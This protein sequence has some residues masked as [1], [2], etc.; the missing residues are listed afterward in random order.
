MLLE[1]GIGILTCFLKTYPRSPLRAVVLTRLFSAESAALEAV[2]VSFSNAS[3]TVGLTMEL[4]GT[5]MVCF[6]LDL[7]RLKKDL[8]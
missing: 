8:K 6:S 1:E 7:F 5:I 2:A 4:L 3:T